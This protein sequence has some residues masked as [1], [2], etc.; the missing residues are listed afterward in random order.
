VEQGLVGAGKVPQVIEKRY[1]KRR[2]QDERAM[3]F[4]CITVGGYNTSAEEEKAPPTNCI[5]CESK[6]TWKD[7]QARL[8]GQRWR[9]NGCRRRFTA[10]GPVPFPIMAFTQ[11]VSD[12]LIA[13][14]SLEADVFA[15]GGD[16]HSQRLISSSF[17]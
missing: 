8:G 11:R 12:D 2:K 17:G 16:C 3:R 9:C 5:R 14:A 1:L 13:L 7:G 15:M 4:C 10:R 6:Q